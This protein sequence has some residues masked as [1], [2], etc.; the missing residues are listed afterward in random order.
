M[1]PLIRAPIKR[2]AALA[3]PQAPMNKPTLAAVVMTRVVVAVMAAVHGAL[4]DATEDTAKNAAEEG[5]TGFELSVEDETA[6]GGR[7]HAPPAAELL[8]ERADACMSVSV[9]CLR[10]RAPLKR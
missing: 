4:N 7:A 6:P 8:R 2:E 3:M 9:A 5:L 10:G 1:A